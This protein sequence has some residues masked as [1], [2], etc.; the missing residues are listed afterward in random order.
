MEDWQG[1]PDALKTPQKVLMESRTS[2]FVFSLHC[3]IY[4][5]AANKSTP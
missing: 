2:D 5:A 1:Y 4:P 3:T